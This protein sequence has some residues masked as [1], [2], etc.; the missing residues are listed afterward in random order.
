MR[1]LTV[2]LPS[3]LRRELDKFCCSENRTLSEVVRES[4]SH[5]LA[6]KRFASLRKKTGPFAEAQ[7][8]LT[9]ED[10]FNAIS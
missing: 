9:D 7:G 2:R 1:T 6:S 5:S 10:V 3:A 8:Y 4:L